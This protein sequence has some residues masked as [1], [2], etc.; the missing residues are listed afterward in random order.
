MKELLKPNP[1]FRNTMLANIPRILLRAT[2]YSRDIMGRTLYVVRKKIKV[3]LLCES[4]FLN[5]HGL[6]THAGFHDHGLGPGPVQIVTCLLYIGAA[7]KIMWDLFIYS[8]QDY[9]KIMLSQSTRL[10]LR[11]RSLKKNK[12]QN[13]LARLHYSCDYCGKVF[14]DES[15]LETH[16]SHA[17]QLQTLQLKEMF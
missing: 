11:F 1:T 16:K 4:K 9:Q 2:R 17:L 14:K 15:K 10:L 3:C 13:M 12:L 6:T 8:A 5:S 7:W